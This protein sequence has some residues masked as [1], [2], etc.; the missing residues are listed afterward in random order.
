MAQLPYPLDWIG[1]GINDVQ[2][3]E[4][5]DHTYVECVCGYSGLRGLLM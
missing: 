4:P 3:G 2:A 1:A 5:G